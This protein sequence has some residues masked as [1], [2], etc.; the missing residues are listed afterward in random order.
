MRTLILASIF[1]SSVWAEEAY[2]ELG[3]WGGVY[4]LGFQEP[5]SESWTGTLGVASYGQYG[6]IVP[7]GVLLDLEILP[8]LGLSSEHRLGLGFF[9]HAFLSVTSNTVGVRLG[10]NKWKVQLEGGWFTLAGW[11]NEEGGTAWGPTVLAKIRMGPVEVW[12]QS[13]TQASALEQQGYWGG[14]KIYAEF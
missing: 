10:H 6:L 12:G 3:G 2:L 8:G 9:D 7:M 5:I 4:S 13:F 14:L 11:A 1:L